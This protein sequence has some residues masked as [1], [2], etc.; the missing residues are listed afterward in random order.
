M[1]SGPGS[2]SLMNTQDIQTSSGISLTNAEKQYLLPH[3]LMLIIGKP[4]SGKTTLITQMLTQDK[5]YGNKKFDDIILVS[6]SH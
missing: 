3:F 2:A 6:P 5:F 1:N 4:G